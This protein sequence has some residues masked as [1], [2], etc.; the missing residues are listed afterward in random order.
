[1]TLL[2]ADLAAIF[3]DT[4]LTVPVSFGTAP[5]QSTRGFPETSD[6][7]ENDVHGGFVLISRRVLTVQ[8]AALS[9]LAK[10]VSI[11]VD[12]V[13]YRI[14]DLRSGGRGKTKVILA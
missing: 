8:D 13:T 7:P 6:V 11:A 5:V 10:N 9:G 12:G 14:H 1:M 2:D 4:S 3:A